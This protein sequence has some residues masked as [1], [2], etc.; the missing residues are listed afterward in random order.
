MGT[1]KQPKQGHSVCCKKP[2]QREAL[3]N[4]ACLPTQLTS[5]LNMGVCDSL[6]LY[7]VA[8]SS[9]RPPGPQTGP[10]DKEGTERSR[11]LNY[12]FLF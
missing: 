5:T 10:L 6:T 7:R 12:I 11:Q 1:L 8:Q 2:V 3:R 4:A 9:T